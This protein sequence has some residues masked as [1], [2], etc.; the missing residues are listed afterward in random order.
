MS[1]EYVCNNKDCGPVCHFCQ[2]Y[3]FNGNEIGAYTNDGECVHPNHPGPRDPGDGCDDYV[4]AYWPDADPEL[5]REAQLAQTA[6]PPFRSD[7]TT[8][9]STGWMRGAEE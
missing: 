3:R 7:E 2:W 4:C 1:A 9:S 8:D 5:R 6:A